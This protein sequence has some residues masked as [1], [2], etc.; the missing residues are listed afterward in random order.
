MDGGTTQSYN[1]PTYQ[2][3]YQG[4]AP[5]YQGGSSQYQGVTPYSQQSFTP[6]TAASQQ[7]TQQ[8]A[9]QPNTTP[10]TPQSTNFALPQINQSAGLPAQGMNVPQPVTTPPPAPITPP[11]AVKQAPVTLAQWQAD[12]THNGGQ[13]ERQQ[14]Y[15]TYLK[16]FDPSYYQKFQKAQTW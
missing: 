11:P 2:G 13:K 8:P 1:R 10:T 16:G 3:G 5:Q 6:F 7:P 4:S 12:P 9:Q 15:I 14:A